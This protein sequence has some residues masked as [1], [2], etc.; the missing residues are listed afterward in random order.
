MAYS[1]E[2][3]GHIPTA[4]QLFPKGSQLP[5][6]PL[7][8]VFVKNENFIDERAFF[9]RIRKIIAYNHADACLWK[10]FA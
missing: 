9:D 4:A 5:Q 3:N 2:Y 1:V 6:R 8:A 7:F 10:V